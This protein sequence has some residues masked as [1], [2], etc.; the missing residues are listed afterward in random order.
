[1]KIDVKMSREIRIIRGGSRGKREEE[2]MGEKYAQ[3]VVYSYKD[4]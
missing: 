4:F 1:M 2:R 3:R